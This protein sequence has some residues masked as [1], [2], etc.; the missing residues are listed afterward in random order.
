MPVD[1]RGRIYHPVNTDELI[2]NI[3]NNKLGLATTLQDIGRSHVIGKARN[4]KAQVI[5]RF[6][7]YRTRQQ[8]YTNK[9]IVK[10]DPEGIFITENLTQFRSNLT[11]K[12]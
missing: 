2:L 6:I 9:K 5:V 12:N 3:L 11:K 8:I 7:S 1:A 10:N 4:G